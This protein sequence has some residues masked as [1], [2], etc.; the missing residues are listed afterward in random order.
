MISKAGEIIISNEFANTTDSA[1]D[2][3]AAGLKNKNGSLTFAVGKH[4]RFSVYR[5]YQPWDSYI[6]I[7]IN[8]NELFAYKYLFVKIV[9][10]LL[11]AVLLGTVLF[12][13]LIQRLLITPVISISKYAN[14]IGKGM[15]IDIHKDGVTIETL[16][17]GVTIMISLSAIN[18]VGRGISTP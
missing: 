10:M 1:F 4:K 7:A 16:K 3:F 8:Q 15:T 17:K 14:Q 13:S 5:F 18:L 2:I 6:G 9:L 11:A 12:S